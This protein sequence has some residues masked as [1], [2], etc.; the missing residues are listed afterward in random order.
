[1]KRALLALLLLSVCAIAQT[2]TKKDAKPPAK[3]EKAAGPS[4]TLFQREWDA[5][6]TL[7]PANAAKY[8]D[9]APEDVFF[10]IE[11]LQYHGWADYDAG[12]KAVLAGFKSVKAKLDEVRIHPAGSA[13]WVTAIVHLDYEL[14]DGTANKADW[15]WTAIWEKRAGDWKIVHE[16]VSAPLAPPEKK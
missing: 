11:P 14:K 3:T 1:M 8:Y 2:T 5:W 10:D 4:A 13:Y 16:H 15:R 6:C 9:T 7:D 12:V